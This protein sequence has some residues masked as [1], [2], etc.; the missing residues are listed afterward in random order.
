MTEPDNGAFASMS[1]G[2]CVFAL[3]AAMLTTL[4]SSIDKATSHLTKLQKT[5][6]SH[7][8]YH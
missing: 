5:A 8:L 2:A 6:A 1:N 3:K 4:R 7:W